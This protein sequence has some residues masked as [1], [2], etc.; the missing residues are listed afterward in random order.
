MSDIIVNANLFRLAYTCVSK[1]ETRYYLNGVFVQPHPVKGA[2][3]VS[4]DGHRLLCI[5][6]KDA[7]APRAEIIQ[8]DATALKVCKPGKGE[9]RREIHI[10]DSRAEIG[11]VIHDHYKGKACE[12]FT[13][14]VLVQKC[15]VDGTFPDWQRV[16]GSRCVEKPALASYN[17]RYVAD[18]AKLGVELR[19]HD[20]QGYRGSESAMRV[21]SAETGSPAL[22]RWPGIDFAFGV[23]MPVRCDLEHRVPDFLDARPAVR[24]DAAA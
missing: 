3:L 6:D 5:Y 24:D 17:G 12:K 1:E 14:T 23:I 4:T 2:F 7:I 11:P 19:A 8:L 20:N 9:V 13:P 16:I 10:V 21:A 22:V 18:F 15:I